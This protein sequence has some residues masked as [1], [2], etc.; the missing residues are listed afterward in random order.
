MADPVGPRS[1]HYDLLFIAGLAFVR[2]PAL[3]GGI[4]IRRLGLEFGRT[5]VHHLIDAGDAGGLAF[6]GTAFPPCRSS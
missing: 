3:K 6:S 1:Q 5:S 4:E 2:M